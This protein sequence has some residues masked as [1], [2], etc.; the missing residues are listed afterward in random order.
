[1]KEKL[2]AIIDIETTGGKANRDRIT[3]IAIV[4]H[5]G[6]KVVDTFETL[7]NPERSIPYNI[8]QI[9]GITQEMV[10]E[11][12]KFYEVAKK[13]VELT[14]DA[15]F[16]AHNVRFDYGFIRE[17]FKSLGFTFM[18]KQLCT[19]RLSRKA[20]PGLRSYSLGNLIRHFGIQVNDRH[21][22]M[23]DTMATVEIFEKI[24][25]QQNIFESV[26]SIVNLGIKESQLPANLSLEKLHQ[27]PE[28]C[29]VYYFLNNKNEVVYVGKSINIKKRIMEHFV[30]KTEK[31]AK[32]QKHV[33][34]ITYEIMGSELL[35]LLFESHEI[36]RIRPTVN[37][38]QKSLSFPYTIHHYTDNAGYLRLN[39]AKLSK[40]EKAKLD[41]VVEY[42]K[43]TI[44]RANMIA[45]IKKFDL[46]HKLCHLDHSENACFYYHIEQ[47]K[48]ACIGNET[49]EIYNLK[50]Q[51]AIDTLSLAFQD[52]FFIIDEGRNSEE[53]AVVL[54]EEGEYKGFGY[55][56]PNAIENNI[57]ELRDTIKPYAHNPETIRIIRQF[58]NKKESVQ[59]VKF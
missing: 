14:K 6:Q 41:I 19:V 31:A 2:Y 13:I 34:D 5:D 53:K 44:A 32:L 11:A 18:R 4:L 45:V 39:I 33:H 40:K 8:T 7:I 21:R 46:C 59:I 47:C 25:G 30:D 42:S 51:Q 24:L 50:A 43:G 23:A 57:E 15:I 48:G 58:L 20:F 52:N 56:D 26:D 16:V 49:P 17:E 36:K 54:I 3:E 28:A 10:D 1:M 38:A 22:A 12:P 27:L 9:T 35:A 29:G 55:F 37:K